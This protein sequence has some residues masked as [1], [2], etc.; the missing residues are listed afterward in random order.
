MDR[1]EKEA[2][3]EWWANQSTCLVRIPVRVTDTANTGEW[4]A[5]ISPPLNH[6]AREDLK[7]LLDADPCLT[8]RFDASAV[9]VQ[10]EGFEDLDHLRLVVIP[11]Q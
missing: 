10:V 9:E 1:D 5:V 11:G 4:E 3:P 6:D 7:L 2:H 8:L